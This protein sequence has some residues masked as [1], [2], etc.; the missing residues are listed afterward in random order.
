VITSA[1]D[2]AELFPQRSA[3]PLGLDVEQM[4]RLAHSVTD[5]VVIG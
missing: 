3:D 5:R 1:D 4:R 2:D